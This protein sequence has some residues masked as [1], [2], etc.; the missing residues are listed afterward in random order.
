VYATETVASASVDQLSDLS[1]DQFAASLN[2]WT[3]RGALQLMAVAAIVI[4]MVVTNGLGLHANGEVLTYAAIGLVLARYVE[5]R[6]RRFLLMLDLG[7]AETARFARLNVALSEL[8]SSGSFRG[9]TQIGHHA[10]WKRSGGATRNLSFENAT[11]RQAV[12]PYI[13]SNITP[14]MLATQGLKLYF[15]PDRVL[16]HSRRKYAALSY[17]QFRVSCD[18][19]RFVWDAIVPHDARVV[20]DTWLY[21]RRDGGPDNRFNNN[22]RIPVVMTAQLTLR[23]STG[24]DVVV[25]STKVGAAEQTAA[26][27]RAYRTVTAIRVA[28]PGL[29]KFATPVANALTVLGLDELPALDKLRQ[30]YRDLIARNQPARIARNSRELQALASH[31][32]AELDAAYAVVRAQLGGDPAESDGRALVP[33]APA[34]LPSRWMRAERIASF[35]AFAA[36][37][38]LFIAFRVGTGSQTMPTTPTAEITTPTVSTT[39]VPVHAPA[40]PQITGRVAISCPLRESP[41]STA[42]VLAG[43]SAGT[44]LVLLGNQASWRRV[45]D[46]SGREGWTGPLCWQPATAKPARVRAPKPSLDSRSLPQ[47]LPSSEVRAPIDPYA[48]VESAAAALPTSTAPSDGR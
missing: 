4:A 21:V 32:L 15:F 3:T 34:V 40:T 36:A 6:R 18:Q 27:A 14:W 47:S 37:L 46:P 26:E 42:R 28:P 44:E 9:V 24:L 43:V 22:R 8:A 16:I 10:D 33:L 11:L 7:P 17:D 20:G 23:S 25:Q 30:D 29:R 39:R 19:T 1:Q 45:R 35:V 12:P 2:E 41:S 31:R 5:R 38:A 13:V 48:P